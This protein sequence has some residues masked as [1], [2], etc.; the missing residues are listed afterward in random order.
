MA[1]SYSTLSTKGSEKLTIDQ[2]RRKRALADAMLSRGFQ[3]T[4]VAPGGQYSAFAG[5]ADALRSALGQYQGQKQNKELDASEAELAA[6]EQAKQATH[7]SLF[8]AMQGQSSTLAEPEMPLGR[9]P[10]PLPDELSAPEP[11]TQPVTPAPGPAAIAPLPPANPMHQQLAG[12]LMQA[13]PGMAQSQAPQSFPLSGTPSQQGDGFQVA[14]AMKGMNAAAPGTI[15]PIVQSAAYGQNAPF[16]QDQQDQIA[17][18]EALSENPDYPPEIMPPGPPIEIGPDGVGTMSP[19]T[20]TGRRPQAALLEAMMAQQPA[21]PT[22]PAPPP[23]LVQALME[24]TGLTMPAPKPQA[25]VTRQA[26]PSQPQDDRW[27][28]LWKSSVAVGDQQGMK[29]A[30]ERM[31]PE[32]KQHV[33]DG[34]LIDS[35]GKVVFQGGTKPK[36]HVVD[37][38]LVDDSGRVI[39]KGAPDELKVVQNFNA[40]LDQSGITDPAAR[41]KMWADYT[42]RHGSGGNTTISFGGPTAGV[43]A[44]G[45]PVFFQPSNKGGA[46]NIMQGV[47]PAP[48]E[49]KPLTESQ[50]KATSFGMRAQAAHDKANS[51]E[52]SSNEIGTLKQAGKDAIPFGFGNYVTSEDMQRYNQA[53][54]EFINAAVL[55]QDS[56][57]AITSSEYEKYNDIYF[58]QKGDKAPAIAQKREAREIAVQGLAV[59]AGESGKKAQLRIQGKAKPIVKGQSDVNPAAVD[60]ER[61]R[62]DAGEPQP[63]SDL[64]AGTTLYKTLPNGNPVWLLP[65]GKK[66]EQHM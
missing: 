12:A 29:F 7:A 44:Q 27:V 56:G 21:A 1:N 6:A 20:V 19:M 53:K 24:K 13:L 50:A 64:P 55:R 22:G 37:G 30:L 65:D 57:A 25:P 35:S 14:D 47:A 10:A 48:K 60:M 26:A 45:N 62:L 5:V 63:P 23:E 28:R 11:V 33:I 61:E 58:P 66:R 54:R 52:A 36:M 49:G 34:S 46:P 31:A 2:I 9:G 42:G 18:T 40:M 51:I 17:D 15:P 59:I 39:Y 32:V 43:D 41:Q 38:A 16:T 3:Q 4:Q 8:D